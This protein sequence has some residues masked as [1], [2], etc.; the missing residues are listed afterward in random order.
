MNPQSAAM[1]SS[2]ALKRPYIVGIAGPS[3]TG[4]TTVAKRV[5]NAL[6]A[7]IISM[8]SFYHDQSGLARADRANRNFDAP[9]AIDSALLL[10]SV[11][12]FSAGKDVNVPVYDFADHTPVLGQFERVRNGPILIVEG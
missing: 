4:K 1:A 8:E 6:G 12:D 10:R 3:G 2:P 9:D 7:R 11:Q 5:A